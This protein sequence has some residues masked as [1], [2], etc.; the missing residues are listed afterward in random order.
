[1]IITSLA[2]YYG[3]L[4]KQ[5]KVALPGYS[6]VNISYALEIDDDGEVEDITS[7]KEPII[8]KTKKGTKT[9]MI[10]KTM[11]VPEVVVRSSN[12]IPNFL[13]DNA[14]YLMGIDNNE[15]KKNEWA[16]IIS[17]AQSQDSSIKTEDTLKDL[18][19]LYSKFT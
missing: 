5:G 9:D 14:S 7:I 19:D 18:A 17:Y 6:K 8:R 13:Y 15:K 16:S 11:I 1:M 10:P 12:T 4:A 3:N 2:K